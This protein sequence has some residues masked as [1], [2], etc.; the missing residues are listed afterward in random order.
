MIVD[1]TNIDISNMKYG[2]SA[3]YN[4]VVKNNYDV[5]IKINNVQ[6][7][8]T[9][10]EATLEGK[11]ELNPGES[12][13][14]KIIFTPGSTGIVKRS[15]FVNFIMNGEAYKDEIIIKAIVS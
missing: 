4:V 7:S 1:R 8:C 12:S 10:T 6:R 5:P 2:T 15:V 3:N 14:I 13:I 9:C 11:S